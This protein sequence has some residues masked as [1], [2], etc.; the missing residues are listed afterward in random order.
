[1]PDT[2]TP[3]SDGP[4]VILPHFTRSMVM[5]AVLAWAFV[6]LATTGATRAAE[7]ALHLP[8]SDPLRLNPAAALF[9]VAV[10]GAAGWVSARRRNEDAFLLALGY[11]PARRWATFLAPP[12]LL[13]LAIATLA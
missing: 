13:E 12:A 6:R 2:V 11:G 8:P 4:V 5:R 1:M 3:I 10:V 9:V 7:A